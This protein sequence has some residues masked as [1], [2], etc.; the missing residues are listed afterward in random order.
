MT[1]TAT[2]TATDSVTPAGPPAPTDK[3]ALR[4]APLD[5]AAMDRLFREARTPLAW[6]DRPVPDGRLEELYDLLKLGPTSANCSPARFLFIRT[7]EGKAR[8]KQAMSP[9]N[10]E[11]TM[12]APV[13]CVVAH[14]QAFHDKL[15]FLLPQADIRGWYADNPSLSDITA[16]RN[17]TL[18]GAYLILAARALGLDAAP[19]SGFD[20]YMVDSLFFAGTRWKSNFLVNLGYG[21]DAALPPRGPRLSFDEACRFE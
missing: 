2:D 12:K 21:D 5:G 16:S 3:A 8:L 17:G 6:Q 14:D 13:V 9:G 18:Q 1:D 7:S 11:R 4:H 15:P 10:I 20:N 19:M